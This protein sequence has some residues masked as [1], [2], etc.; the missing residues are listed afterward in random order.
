M[1]LKKEFVNIKEISPKNIPDHDFLL[2]VFFAKRF[3]M[4]GKI[5]YI[6][7]ALT[8]SENGKD[9]YVVDEKNMFI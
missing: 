4:V 6:Y 3:L 9:G 5:V 7:F 1:N 8:P 2:L